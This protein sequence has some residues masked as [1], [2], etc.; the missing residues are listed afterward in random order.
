MAT[1]IIRIIFLIMI[2]VGL[3]L[4]ITQK[5]WVVP[6]TNYLVEYFYVLPVYSVVQ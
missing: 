3:A 2:I 6:L 5:L 1:K 4:I